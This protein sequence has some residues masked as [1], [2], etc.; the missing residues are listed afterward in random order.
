M[1][2]STDPMDIEIDLH[3]KGF[4][5][6]TG[7]ITVVVPGRPPSGQSKSELKGDFRNRFLQAIGPIKWIFAHQV[8]VRIDLHIDH[9]AILE[10]DD[11]ADVDNYAK[12][13]FDAIKGVGDVVID[14]CQIFGLSIGWIDC[15]GTEYEHVEIEFQSAPDDF[16]LTPIELIELSDGLYYPFSKYDWTVNGPS[17]VSEVEY[18][19]RVLRADALA[20][21]KRKLRHE[22]RQNGCGEPVAFQDVRDHADYISQAIDKHAYIWGFHRTRATSSGFPMKRHADWSKVFVDGKKCDL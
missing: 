13:I 10:S 5:P 15:A 4:N 3:N 7:R 12:A 1:S 16:L 11:V 2:S 19:K 6:L 8:S 17:Q 21:Q 18:T 20:I 14:D 22:A 9:Q